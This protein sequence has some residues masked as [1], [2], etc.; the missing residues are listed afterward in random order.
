VSGAEARDLRAFQ[1]PAIGFDVMTDSTDSSF[2][3]STVSGI[4]AGWGDPVDPTGST[5]PATAVA[6][7]VSAE[8]VRV[9]IDRG[10]ATRLSGVGGD[11]YLV[12]DSGSAVVSNTCGLAG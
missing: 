4:E 7:K 12:D 3:G 10:C 5:A 11:W 6:Y 9:T 8:A 2:V 1:G